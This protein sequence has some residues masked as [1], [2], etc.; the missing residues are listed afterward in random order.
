VRLQVFD[1]SGKLVVTLV[2]AQQQKGSHASEWRGINA[3]G[4]QVRSGVYFYRLVTRAQT[5]TH[6]MVLLR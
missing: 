1:A 6:K 3:G 4:A 2:D 5:L